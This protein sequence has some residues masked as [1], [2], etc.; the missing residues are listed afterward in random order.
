[1]SSKGYG[2][3]KRTLMNESA[4]KSRERISG[5]VSQIGDLLVEV[6]SRAGSVDHINRLSGER[7]EKQ[8]SLSQALRTAPPDELAFRTGEIDRLNRQIE[9][10]HAPFAGTEHKL[11]V[12]AAEVEHALRVIPVRPL[13]LREIRSEVRELDMVRQAKSRQLVSM[14][15]ARADLWV[16]KQRLGEMLSYLPGGDRLVPRPFPTPDGTDWEDVQIRFCSDHTIQITV[17]GRSEP[18][19]FVEAGFEDGRSPDKPT[20]AWQFLVKLATDG[21]ECDKPRSGRAA[22]KAETTVSSLRKG[23][24]CLLSLDG[25]PIPYDRGHK[26]YKAAFKLSYPD[27]D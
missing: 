15:A 1:M 21:G 11:R 13:E 22:T 7:D 14:E 25:D 19:T 12:F 23:L 17:L 10:L 2:V 8:C 16:L 20:L 6:E 9:A 18:R 3:S 27:P 4:T 26:T 5:C 24:R